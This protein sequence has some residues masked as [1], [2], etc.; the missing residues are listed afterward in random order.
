MFTVQH[1]QFTWTE[2]FLTVYNQ[3]TVVCMY[4]SER[5]RE[6]CRFK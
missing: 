3:N 2:P 4:G 1:C 6:M 5:D